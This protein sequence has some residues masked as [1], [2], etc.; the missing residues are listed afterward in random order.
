[1]AASHP[2]LEKAKDGAPEISVWDQETRERVGHPPSGEVYQTN[3]HYT[4]F[5]KIAGP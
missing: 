3:D 5:V 4:S 1:L 2:A